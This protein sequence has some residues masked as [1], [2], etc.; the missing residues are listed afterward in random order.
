MKYNCKSI[1]YKE[2]GYFGKIVTDY[3]DGHQNLQSFYEYTPDISGIQQAVNNRK[4]FIT[5]RLELVNYFKNQYANIGFTPLQL[6]NVDQLLLDNT[7]TVTTAHQPNLFTGP[8][9]FIYKIVH[10]IV[11]ANYLKQEIPDCNFVPIYFMGSEDA[12]LQEL[13]SV[14]VNQKKYTWHTKQTGAVGRMRVDDALLKLLAELEN[15]LTVLPF[16][17]PIIEILKSGYVKDRKIDEATLY[18]VNKLFK[19]YGLLVLIP[20][21]ERLKFLFKEIAKREL[22]QKFSSK[23]I[24]HTNSQLIQNGYNTQAVGRSINLFLLNDNKRLRIEN[25][26]DKYFV[27][28]RSIIFNANEI[29]N[30]IEHHYANISP[31]VILRPIFQELILPNIAFIGGGGELAYWL[32]LKQVFTEAAIPYPVLLLRNSFGFTE[33]GAKQIWDNKFF[34]I[35]T[36]FNKSPEFEKDLITRQDDFISIRSEVEA[37]QQLYKQLQHK[38]QPLDKT[39]VQHIAA[40]EKKHNNHLVELEKKIL[41]KYKKLHNQDVQQILKAKQQLFPN[42][43]LQEREESGLYWLAKYGVEWLKIVTSVS[44]PFTKQ[45]KLVNVSQ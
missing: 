32:Q 2:T 19:N 18:I 7:F 29:D 11:L 25:E 10:A 27:E 3:L 37:F 42:N 12:D 1:D 5:N 17:K 28:D 8:L 44:D 9:Y 36:L 16:G 26:L 31:N 38:L 39:L 43:K 33:Y 6:Q 24:T 4:K 30:F 20:D 35:N 34:N 14:T 15:H 22:K 21:D 23:S 13:G 40:L 45:F 41:R